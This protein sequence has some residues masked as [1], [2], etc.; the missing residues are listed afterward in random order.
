MKR[1]VLFLLL[2]ISMIGTTVALTSCDFNAPLR[3]KMINY[4]SD[5]S[6]YQNLE[7]IIT[8]LDGHLIEIDILTENTEFDRK[9]VNGYQDFFLMDYPEF[10]DNLNVGDKISFVSAPMCFYNGDHYRIVSL[11]KEGEVYLT[12]EKGKAENLEWI[13]IM[14]S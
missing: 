11:E 9:P 4:Y 12:F 2:L 7:G 10:I 13:A 1:A 5:D 3:N 14:F 8:S 6:N